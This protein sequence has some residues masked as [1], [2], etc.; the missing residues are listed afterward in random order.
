MSAGYRIAGYV[1]P[2]A[3]GTETPAAGS[4]P[5]GATTASGA[6]S[7]ASWG[8]PSASGLAN[9]DIRAQVRA[10]S[11]ATVS[12]EVGGVLITLLPEGRR[13]DK[14]HVLARLD[15][16]LFVAQRDKS[17]VEVS[18]AQLQFKAQERLAQ[19]EAGSKTDL[20]LARNA[21]ERLQSELRIMETQVSKCTIAAPF[22]GVVGEN[23][24][25]N[26]QF[27]QPGQA[28]MVVLDDGG[29]EIE[30]LAPSTWLRRI[31]PGDEVSILVDELGLSIKAQVLRTGTRV[32]PVSQSVKVV[33]QLLNPP[34][35]L[36]AGMSG[37]VAMAT[38]TP[39]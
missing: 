6:A 11:Q 24:Q 14:G 17:R 35:K 34:A 5:H 23:L 7:G 2:D 21:V 30:F 12:A 32:D 27:V 19:L 16:S 29:Y 18:A 15:C 13:F 25:Q 26:H 3:S 38:P 22:N 1:A 36:K 9:V 39:P 31:A 37:R 4:L 33:A 20:A 8:A 10:R 28:L